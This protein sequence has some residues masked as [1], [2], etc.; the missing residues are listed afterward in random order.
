MRRRSFMAGLGAAG[1]G[2]VVDN[3]Q[4][5][6]RVFTIPLTAA[7]S[8]YQLP[9]AGNFVQ[10]ID[11]SNPW[12]EISFRLVSGDRIGDLIPDLKKGRKYWGEFTSLR[13]T[14]P[15]QASQTITLLIG[16]TGFVQSGWD[17]PSVISGQQLVSVNPFSGVE[18]SEWWRPSLAPNLRIGLNAV[19]INPEADIWAAVPGVF[20]TLLRA[21]LAC[22]VAG[23]VELKDTAG[24]SYGFYPFQANVPILIDWGAIGIQLAVNSAFRAVGPA[25]STLSGTLMG[26]NTAA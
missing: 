26:L 3:P 1:V 13:I 17:A 8:D 14:S 25:A 21:Y 15:A 16:R 4:D 22:S 12:V 24:T 23:N 9:I 2:P 20:H 7:L 19:A 5:T 18:I 6:Y 11:S 10:A